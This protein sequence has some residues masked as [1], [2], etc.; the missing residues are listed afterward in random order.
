MLCGFSEVAEL[1]KAHRTWVDEALRREKGVREG[2]WSEAIAVGNLNFV[3]AVKSEL[4]FRAA[5]REVIAEHGGICA[6]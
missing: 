4:G 3:E 2:W 1:Q 6:S 5:H